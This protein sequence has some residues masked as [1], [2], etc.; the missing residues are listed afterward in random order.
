MKLSPQIGLPNNVLSSLP[1][2]AVKVVAN[3]LGKRIADGTYPPGTTIPMED[4]LSREHE[5]SRT[6]LRE[7]IKVLSAKG[8]VQTA[9]RHGTRVRAFEDWHLLDPDVIHWHTPS[10]PMAGRIRDEALVLRA[11]VEPEAARL[12]AENAS[13][14]QAETILRAALSISPAPRDFE[15]VMAADYEFHATVLEATG[16]A[17]LSQ[18]RGVILATLQFYYRHDDDPR[19][20][21]DQLRADHVAV[22][23][24][25]VARDPASAKMRMRAMLARNNSQSA[26]SGIL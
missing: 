9:R 3:S 5:V 16:N 24:A 1:K 11:I 13:E 6:V 10:S 26:A 17:M 21:I 18:L 20:D 14:A 12:A 22:A 23:E 2:G 15:S 4:I 7:A 19:K 8:L 25:I